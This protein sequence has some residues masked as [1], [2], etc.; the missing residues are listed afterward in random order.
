MIQ[1][2]GLVNPEINQSFKTGLFRKFGIATVLSV[3]FL[4]LV[5]GIVRSSGSGMGCPDWPKCFGQWIPPTDVNELPADYQSRFSTE[6]IQV[7]EFSAFHTWTEYLNR[8]LGVIIGILIFITLI[9][10]FPLRKY[11]SGIFYF[12]L[13]GFLL[14]GFQGWLGA[15]VVAT[16]LS[17]AIITLHMLLAL[18]ITGCLVAGVSLAGGIYG[19][20][21]IAPDQK[22]QIW[23]KACMTLSLVQIVLGTQVRENIDNIAIELGEARRGE[24]INYLSIPFYIHR[25]LSILFIICAVQLFRSINKTEIFKGFKD[26]PK[27]QLLLILISVAIGMILSYG[28][29]P[30]FAQPLHLL[31][32]SILSGIL[33]YIGILIYVRPKSDYS[34]EEVK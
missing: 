28:G 7:S 11:R 22:Y 18:V 20:S 14:V 10:S 29:M 17:P 31:G 1:R 5:G 19:L 30:A 32:G 25:S 16:D 3:Y 27:I 6:R 2:T 8:L 15:Q 21:P 34:L 13:A 33:I 9:L 24:W 4:I 26:L 23:W 12:S